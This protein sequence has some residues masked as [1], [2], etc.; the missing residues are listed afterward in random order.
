MVVQSNLLASN[1]RMLVAGCG[2][3]TIE[4]NLYVRLQLQTGDV[5]DSRHHYRRAECFRQSVL[6][7]QKNGYE[8]GTSRQSLQEETLSGAKLILT[9]PPK[10]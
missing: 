4:L 10:V 9:S 1:N 3:F 6:S 8:I 2:P 7:I 5:G